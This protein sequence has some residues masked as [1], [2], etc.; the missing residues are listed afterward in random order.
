[1]PMLKREISTLGLCQDKSF[2]PRSSASISTMF[3]AGEAGGSRRGSRRRGRRAIPGALP[4]YALI[5]VSLAD[6]TRVVK[7]TGL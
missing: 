1:M 7:K 6:F 2:H 5:Y 4:L 3:G